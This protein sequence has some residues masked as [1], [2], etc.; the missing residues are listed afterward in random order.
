[1]LYTSTERG[2]NQVGQSRMARKRNQ[3]R[4][5]SRSDSVN[6]YPPGL[7]IFHPLS[8]YGRLSTLPTEYVSHLLQ[9]LGRLSL[10]ISD[11][12]QHDRPPNTKTVLSDLLHWLDGGLDSAFANLFNWRHLDLGR[13]TERV[14]GNRKAKPR[15]E[16]SAAITKM[17]NLS[18]CWHP[19]GWSESSFDWRNTG[20]HRNLIECRKWAEPPDFWWFVGDEEPTFQGRATNELMYIRGV[21][22]L[23]PEPREQYGPYATYND[24]VVDSILICAVRS[25]YERLVTRL[26]ESFD[27][28]VM[29]AFDFVTRD[30][31]RDRDPKLNDWPTKR[32]IGWSLEDAAQLRDRRALAEQ[33]EKEQRERGDLEAVS[34]SH[35]CSIEQIIEALVRAYSSRPRGRIVSDENANRDAAKSLRA[36][37]AQIDTGDIRRIRELMERY[38]AETIPA[39][40]RRQMRNTLEKTSQI[41]SNVVLLNSRR[42]DEPRVP[43]ERS[44]TPQ[45]EAAPPVQLTERRTI[46]EEVPTTVEREA[47]L[48]RELERSLEILGCTLEAVVEALTRAYSRQAGELPLPEDQVN[49]EAAKALRIHGARV[50]SEGLRRLRRLVEHCK[51][52]LLPIT[53]P[54]PSS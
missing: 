3:K 24:D 38:R 49:R 54:T 44:V 25:A 37:G 13:M 2:G 4:S 34:S 9:E 11:I 19:G 51:P 53:T 42:G 39:T 31:S 43:S 52:G 21:G 45:P 7:K 16:V 5:R 41:F 10:K 12:E 47:Q 27:V 17:N 22:N 48:A 1:V 36:T 23:D 6:L 33:A 18:V 32:V 8:W 50:D 30:E 28:V 15:I 40:L 29:D 26:E 20:E 46:K 35:G 14:N